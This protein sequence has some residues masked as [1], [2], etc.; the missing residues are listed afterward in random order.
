MSDIVVI[1]KSLLPKIWKDK[2]VSRTIDFSQKQCVAHVLCLGAGVQSSTIAEMS[3][4]DDLPPFDFA[5]FADTKNEPP[6]VYEQVQYLSDK[7]PVII[8]EKPDGGL[9]F[10]TK[11]GYG[12]F[13]SMPFYTKDEFGNV[14]RLKRQCTSEYKI[15]VIN[16]YLRD[17]L[18]ERGYGKVAS[19]GSRRIGKE[20]YIESW[21]GI[22][23]DEIERLKD[24]STAWEKDIYPLIDKRITREECIKYLK[25]RGLPVPG[26]S[27]CIV[28]AFH[29]DNY[30]LDLSVNHPDVFEEACD[31][32]N[33]IRSDEARQRLTSGLK[34]DVYLH[35]SCQPLRE[36]DFSHTPSEWPLFC[37][38]HC[39]T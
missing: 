15:E 26:K 13:V 20:F 12:R 2:R 9:V 23:Y 19:D 38:A 30:W 39:M 16:D 33:W 17:W 37:S 29:D 14:G 36:V 6:W 25:A 24:R 34:S 11:S 7:L 18:I 3:L 22:S 31:F 1:Q 4:N 27:S 21:F 8:V 28:C 32:D 5:I 35:K 10:N